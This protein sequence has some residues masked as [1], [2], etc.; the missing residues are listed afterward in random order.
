MSASGPPKPPPT[1]RHQRAV[2]A[3]EALFRLFPLEAG[4]WLSDRLHE[5]SKAI[6]ILEASFLEQPPRGPSY[7]V[8]APGPEA[9]APVTTEG[10]VKQV[11]AD[12]IERDAAESGGELQVVSFDFNEAVRQT[13]ARG[14]CEVELVMR[15]TDGDGEPFPTLLGVT[16]AGEQDDGAEMHWHVLQKSAWHMNACHRLFGD[17][18][19]KYGFETVP[20]YLWPGTGLKDVQEDC[21]VTKGGPNLP[22]FLGA[23]LRARSE[24]EQE[25]ERRRRRKGNRER[26]K[27]HRALDRRRREAADRRRAL[28]GD[29]GITDEELAALV[30]AIDLELDYYQMRIWYPIV[31]LW[32]EPV[33]ALLEELPP[34]CVGLSFFGHRPPGVS[35]EDL[36]GRCA[37][38]LRRASRGAGE[39]WTRRAAAALAALAAVHIEPDEVKRV[40]ARRRLL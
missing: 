14:G 37:W 1:E 10:L 28:M 30:P 21:A 25:K 31:R 24:A 8:P 18:M 13:M 26:L 36:L 40:L 7:V 2:A 17:P 33:D 29:A 39:A 15:A 4:R 27:Y 34:E 23:L 16:L 9:E 22:G 38:V 20:V 6:K 12:A 3:I 35:A 32:E 19:S 5:P 11:I